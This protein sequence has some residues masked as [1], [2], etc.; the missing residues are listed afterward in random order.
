MLARLSGYPWPGNVRELENIV[1]RAVVLCRGDVIVASDLPPNMAPA[2][3][4]DGISIP[5]S[6]LDEIERYAILKT[7]E[8]TGGSTSRAAEMLGISVRKI[9]YKLH[10]Y[11]SVPKGGVGAVDTS[12]P[13]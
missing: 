6:T 2:R 11:Q 13:V 9:Q 1:E 5:G 3:D 4:T 7:L 8:A 10:E 12:K